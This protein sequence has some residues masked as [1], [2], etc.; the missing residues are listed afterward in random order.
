ML[1]HGTCSHR[2]SRIEAWREGEDASSSYPARPNQASL[3]GTNVSS[4]S[5]TTHAD[6]RRCVPR[7]LCSATPGGGTRRRCLPSDARPSIRG[8][9][10][11][12]ERILASG[13]YVVNSIPLTG[14]IVRSGEGPRA[15]PATDRELFSHGAG[16]DQPRGGA[17]QPKGGAAQPKGGAVQ[18]RGGA[19]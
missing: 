18:P 15:C 16:A 17:A 10:L 12:L 8:P 9:Y 4:G 5:G 2:E 1:Q 11:S 19:V 6:I 3:L 14:R 13:S 7:S